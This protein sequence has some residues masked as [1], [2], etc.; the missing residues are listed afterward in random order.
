MAGTPCALWGRDPLLWR[1]RDLQYARKEP[2][3]RQ[4]P[5][6]SPKFT[7]NFNLLGRRQKVRTAQTY[8]NRANTA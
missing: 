6:F 4:R 5:K 8:S 2:L 1:P 7:G 3:R